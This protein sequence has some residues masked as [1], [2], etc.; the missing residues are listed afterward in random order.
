MQHVSSD[1][2]RHRP[3]VQWTVVSHER[4]QTSKELDT[5]ILIAS[6]MHEP[7]R[8]LP[9]ASRVCMTIWASRIIYCILCNAIFYKL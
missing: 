5:S 4:V 8:P 7:A 9:R 1:Y 2:E 3:V 6:R